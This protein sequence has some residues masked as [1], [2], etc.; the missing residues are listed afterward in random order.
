MK[1]CAYCGRENA[2]NGMR[3]CECGTEEFVDPASPPPAAPPRKIENRVE[4]PDP[5][6]DV[7]PDDESALCTFCL[8]PN[9]PEISWCKR[10]GGPI[11]STTS[12]VPTDAILTMG[13]VYRGAV[14]G[15]PKLLVLFGVW[16]LFF[17]GFVANGLVLLC[18]LGGVIGGMGGVAYFWSSLLGGAICST[19]LY[20]AT[21]N[22]IVGG[23][24]KAG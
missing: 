16:I 24:S 9:R 22:Y 20:R 10:C 19:M 6:P 21:R 1:N 2:D 23:S 17:P 4:I 7:G 8:F 5:E 18:V 3:C 11:G 13:F 12:I 15:N 14:E